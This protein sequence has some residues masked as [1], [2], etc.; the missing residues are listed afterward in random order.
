MCIKIRKLS[1][2]DKNGSKL[3]QQQSKKKNFKIKMLNFNL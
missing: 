2:A 1:K 3:D